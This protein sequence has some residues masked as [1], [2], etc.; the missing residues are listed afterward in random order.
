MGS[1]VGEPKAAAKQPEYARA[2]CRGKE[3][4]RKPNGTEKMQIMQPKKGR[5]I[6][7]TVLE[8]QVYLIHLVF[9]RKTC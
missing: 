3:D 9:D 1:N 2:E 5:I 6:D 4:S 8:N 7:T